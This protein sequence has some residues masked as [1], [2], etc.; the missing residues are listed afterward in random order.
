MLSVAESCTGGLIG[1][2]LT[3]VP[4]S[5]TYFERGA[6]TYSNQ[7]K[8]EML[9]V[10]LSLLKRYGAVSSPSRSGDGQRYPYESA[11]PISD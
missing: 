5:S 9:G 6:M 4:G 1:H 7:A 2:R 3:Q 11:M 8:H 10:P